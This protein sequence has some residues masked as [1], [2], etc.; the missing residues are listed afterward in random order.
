MQVHCDE[1]VAT[2][3]GPEPCVLAGDGLD[4]ASVGEC[5]G[6]PLSRGAPGDRQ[7][8]EGASPLR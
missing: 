1:G 6:Q 5:A 7:E 8:V 2:R 4:E 3:I